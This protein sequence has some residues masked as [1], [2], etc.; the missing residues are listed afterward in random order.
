MEEEK[1]KQLAKQLGDCLDGAP[2]SGPVSELDAELETAHLLLGALGGLPELKPE[3]DA[4]LRARLVREARKRK[5]GSAATAFQRR[6]WVQAAVAA[7]FVAILT[8]SLWLFREKAIDP[9][10]LEKVIKYDKMYVPFSET[11]SERNYGG[12]VELFSDEYGEKVREMSRSAA[13]RRTASYYDNFRGE[14]STGP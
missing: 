8:P 6:K 10:K 12:R 9:A 4:T 5:A 2:A 1:E 3:F 14:R 7:L 11:M 13:R